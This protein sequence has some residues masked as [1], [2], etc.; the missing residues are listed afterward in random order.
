MSAVND[1]LNSAQK[2]VEAFEAWKID[3]DAAMECYDLEEWLVE[4][5][6]AFGTV[7][8]TDIAIRRSQYHGLLD[9][10]F[11]SG[12]RKLYE[13]WLRTAESNLPALAKYESLFGV[14]KHADEFRERI[15]RAQRVIENW[16]ETVQAQAPAMHPWLV[17][18]DDAVKLHA[19]V[20]ALPG[21]PG[22]LTREPEPMAA[23]DASLIR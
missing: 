22:T 17:S 14:V 9:S 15:T 12:C 2:H 19:L 23:G 20:Q 21:S 10:D 5:L 1:K 3:H 8:R 13:L 16:T 11:L 7:V 4:G 18:E 6:F